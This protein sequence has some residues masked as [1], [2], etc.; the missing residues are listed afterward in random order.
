MKR[1]DISHNPRIPVLMELVNSMNRFNDPA[2]LLET[3]IRAMRRAY[4]ARCYVQISTR[5][6][7]PGEYRIL[8]LRTADD[9]EHVD[10]HAALGRAD[11]PICRGGILGEAI[12]TGRPTIL[13]DLSLRSDPVLGRKL[14]DYR[15]LMATP[16]FDNSIGMQWLV[17]LDERHAAFS[18][19]D[20]EE[21]ILRTNLVGAMITNLE[22]AYKLSQAHDQIQ[23][24]IDAIARIQKALLPRELPSIP[25]L[26]LAASYRTFDRA[27]GDLYDIAPLAEG[28]SNWRDAQEQRWAFLIGDVSG[29]GP[30]AAV[31]MAMCHAIQHAYPIRPAGPGEMLGHLNRH[32]CATRIEQSFVTAFL[33]FY[34]ASTRQLT[35]AR[36]GHNPPILKQFPHHGPPTR[37]DA[38]GELPLGIFHDVQYREASITLK[39]GQTLILYTDGITEARNPAG[40]LFGIEGIEKSL[41]A[42]TGAPDC[43]IRHIGEALA[44]H[45]ADIR[46]SDDQTIIA[47]QVV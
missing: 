37:L 33:G 2:E 12:I 34:D 11:W 3:F 8:R 20:L 29:H 17:V 40:E 35:Y 38:V 47:I 25:G 30:A 9:I 44:M 15:S 22:T 16:L 41:I 23:R 39:P 1:V 18:E 27:G 7:A 43:A 6:L 4:G 19:A 42:C 14:A 5:G 46:A 24:E 10:W 13:H 26:R 28:M 32:L 36:A 31:V 21:S 45:Q